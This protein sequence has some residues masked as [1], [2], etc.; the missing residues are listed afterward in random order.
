MKRIE[1]KNTVTAGEDG[2]FL[3][4]GLALGRIHRATLA[5]TGHVF[6]LR[7]NQ[8]I[9]SLRREGKEAVSLRFSADCLR[10]H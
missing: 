8:V 1:S 10:R 7:Q 9:S 6:R 2:A 5:S 3:D 4:A